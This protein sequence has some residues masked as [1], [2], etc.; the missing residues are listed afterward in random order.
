MI[1]V[2]QRGYD[3]SIAAPNFEV[4]P[5]LNTQLFL[6]KEALEKVLFQPA[7]DETFNKALAEHFKLINK[8]VD[9]FADK[10][11]YRD[12]EFVK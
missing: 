11:I 6:A 7:T 1:T 3:V 9:E 4:R 10:I 5:D 8:R 12:Y 2:I